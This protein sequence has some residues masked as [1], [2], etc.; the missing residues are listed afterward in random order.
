M[1]QTTT[2]RLEVKRQL[3]YSA[4][5]VQQARCQA[6]TIC[7]TRGERRRGWRVDPR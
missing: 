5:S 3:Y 1:S 7:S 6:M 2:R 4:Y